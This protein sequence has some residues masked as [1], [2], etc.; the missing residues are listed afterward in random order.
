MGILCQYLSGILS[1]PIERAFRDTEAMPLPDI[2]IGAKQCPATERAGVERRYWLKPG[3]TYV[4]AQPLLTVCYKSG[5]QMQTLL[6]C[7]TTCTHSQ[8][9]RVFIQCCLGADAQSLSLLIDVVT[10]IYAGLAAFIPSAFSL[11]AGKRASDVN[12]H[13]RPAHRRNRAQETRQTPSCHALSFVQHIRGSNGI[14]A[15]CRPSGDIS[16]CQSDHKLLISPVYMP[17]G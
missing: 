13:L 16:S 5:I 10:A 12:R 2:V 3:S 15:A 7:E 4:S 6:S 9:G 17:M 11:Y 14:L 1:T 8:V